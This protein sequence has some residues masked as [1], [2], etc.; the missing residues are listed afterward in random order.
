[1]TIQDVTIVDSRGVALTRV[2]SGEGEVDAGGMRLDLKR[3]TE[4]YLSRKA[5][6]VLDRVFGPGHALA[7]VDVTLNMDQMRVTTEDVIPAP[8]GAGSGR[9]GVIVKERE[10]LR[11]MAPPLDARN[12][13]APRASMN[14]Q[15]D[16]DYAV[17]RRVEQV[18][19][20]PGSIRRIQVVVVVRRPLDAA[21]QEQV[22]KLLAGAVGAVEE[23]GDTVV[24]QAL[25]NLA[26]A[27]YGVSHQP[28]DSSAP[29]D[30]T[31]APGPVMG[32]ARGPGWQGV[33]AVLALALLAGAAVV[34]SRRPRILA[35]S[36]LSEAQ[37]VAALR[38]VQDWMR[39]DAGSTQG[40][41]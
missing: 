2:A 27:A 14:S 29:T 4:G 28:P 10:T 33:V 16:V 30:T 1:M 40:G 17:G 24:V 31:P 37:R 19:G 11:D 23:R 25:E 8:G 5:S 38:Q 21:Q 20:Q 9:T 12:D 26:P 39:A 13:A 6:A 18:I 3:D 35:K 22:S 36:G 32:D 34:F 41:R 7:S 15:R